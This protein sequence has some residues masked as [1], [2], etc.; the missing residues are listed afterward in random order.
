MS[1]ITRETDQLLLA[2]R[3][4]DAYTNF[5][6]QK[7]RINEFPELKKQVDDFR[8]RN[9][10]LQTGDND[11]DLFEAISVFEKEYA[12][13]REEPLVADFLAAELEL[14]RMVQEVYARILGSVE[15][16]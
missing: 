8:I 5:E 7:K 11:I 13:F 9:F 16:E 1:D 14:C 3:Q 15:I 6:I 10:E 4:T 12:E 2:I